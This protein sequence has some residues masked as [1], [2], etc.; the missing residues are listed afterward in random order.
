MLQA[1]ID[2]CPSNLPPLL[3]LVHITD[4]AAA[5]TILGEKMLKTK[6]CRHYS[7]LLKAD[8]QL[9]YLSYGRPSYRGRS[10]EKTT[11]QA[12]RK[13]IA[14]ILKPAAFVANVRRVSPFDSGA[15][16]CGKLE[17]WIDRDSLPIANFEP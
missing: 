5:R 9:L 1:Y 13:P 8:E 6:V 4:V 3:P 16:F 17:D 12:L 2:D 14:F 7:S 15:Y 10:H 11:G